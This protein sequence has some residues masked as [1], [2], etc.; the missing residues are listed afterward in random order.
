MLFVARVKKILP[1][2]KVFGNRSG[3]KN[4][5]KSEI[6]LMR[7]DAYGYDGNHGP[8]ESNSLL[9]LRILLLSHL[10]AEYLDSET[11]HPSSHYPA[12]LGLN[13]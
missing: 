13:L 7:G 1:G 11:I 12:W 9:P 10:P 3:M 4:L 2:H 6:W 5:P 8:A